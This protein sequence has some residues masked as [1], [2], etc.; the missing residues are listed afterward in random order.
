MARLCLLD[1]SLAFIQSCYRAVEFLHS[2]CRINRK[3]YPLV[4]IVCISFGDIRTIDF[5]CFFTYLLASSPHYGV[6]MSIWNVFSF[7]QEFT[8]ASCQLWRV[9]AHTLASTSYS[10]HSSRI[11]FCQVRLSHLR[12]AYWWWCSRNHL[13]VPS[14]RSE[15]V[16]LVTNSLSPRWKPCFGVLGKHRTAQLI[17]DRALS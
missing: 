16:T 17:D 4:F 10:T 13:K 7:L 6:T 3:N 15:R 9:I 2:L 5:Y 11:S 1:C 12:G 14:I 8:A